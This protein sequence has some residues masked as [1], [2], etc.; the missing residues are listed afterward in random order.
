MNRPSYK[1]MVE[2]IFRLIVGTEMME[3]KSNTDRRTDQI[4]I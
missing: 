3:M 1:K 2:P 4:N